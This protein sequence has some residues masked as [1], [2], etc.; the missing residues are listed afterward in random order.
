MGHGQ[1]GGSVARKKMMLFYFNYN[2]FKHLKRDTRHKKQISN[3]P[4]IR[5]IRFTFH[6]DDKNP[7]SKL[8]QE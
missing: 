6:K 7:L 2:V 3:K 4:Q 8:L 1:T 5:R